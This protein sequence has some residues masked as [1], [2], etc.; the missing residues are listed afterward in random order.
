[1][2]KSLLLLSAAAL[3]AGCAT[4]VNTPD[5]A[6]EAIDT[7]TVRLVAEKQSPTKGYYE[8]DK[9]M[10]W[11]EGDEICVYVTNADYSSVE[12]RPI[13]LDQQYDGATKADFDITL[14]DGEYLNW[15][16]WYPYA[17]SP[18]WSQI[19]PYQITNG[20]PDKA[21]NNSINRMFYDQ[22]T[23]MVPMY[24][25]AKVDGPVSG[26]NEIGL[27]FKHIA[28]AFKFSF[29]G[30]PAD[31]N[32][33]RVTAYGKQ[34]SGGFTQTMNPLDESTWEL[35]TCDFGDENNVSEDN[36]MVVM[37][38]V[39]NGNPSSKDIYVPVPTGT[40]PKFKV[41][42]IKR[43]Y[44]YDEQTQTS[45][46][47]DVVYWE[48]TTTNPNTVERGQIV[49]MP[50]VDIPGL[51]LAGSFNNWDSDGVAFEDVSGHD[52]WKAV[53]N[54]ALTANDEFKITM[55]GGWGLSYGAK[56]A[57]KVTV[58][59]GDEYDVDATPGSQN[60][61]VSADG[62]YDIYFQPVVGTLVVLNA[63]DPF[64]PGEVH[65]GWNLYASFDGTGWD[66]IEMA[67]EQIIDPETQNPMSFRTV[68]NVEVVN[69]AAPFL[70]NLN[71]KWDYKFGMETSGNF[72]VDY[73]TEM[74]LGGADAYIETA[75]KYD[76]YFHA[77]ENNN[78]YEGYLL[79]MPAGQQPCWTYSVKGT[80]NNWGPDLEATIGTEYIYV[81]NVE[82]GDNVEFILRYV[83]GLQVVHATADEVLPVGSYAIGDFSGQ[84]QY[85]FKFA[86]V[87]GEKY[88]ILVNAQTGEVFVVKT[89]EWPTKATGWNLIGIGGHWD[90]YSDILM[91]DKTVDN[92]VWRF[93]GNVACVAD[94]EFQFRKDAD[95]QEQAGWQEL[96]SDQKGYPI[97]IGDYTVFDGDKNVRIADAG[98][99]DFYFDPQTRKGIVVTAG[100]D[101]PAIPVEYSIFVLDE[102]GWNSLG[103]IV[104]DA[105]DNTE[106]LNTDITE[107]ET[108]GNF[109]YSTI[110]F[111]TAA[112]GK[113]VNIA[114]TN[115]YNTL[116]DDDLKNVTLNG[117]IYTRTNG[118]MAAIISDPE[119][120]DDYNYTKGPWSITGEFNGWSDYN[121]TIH[122]DYD[123]SNGT[124]TAENVHFNAGE[125]FKFVMFDSWGIN[126]GGTVTTLGEPFDVTPN[127]DNIV[128]PKSGTYTVTL[129]DN[130]TKATLTL[131]AEDVE[132]EYSVVGWYGDGNGGDVNWDVANGV[133][134]TKVN[135]DGWY[136]A[137]GI[138]AASDKK[139][140]FKFVHNKSWDDY[141]LGAA[142]N[143]AKEVNVLFD[144][145]VKN[146]NYNVVLN[147]AGTYDVYFNATLKQA[148]I[149]D[150]G[151]TFAVP[152]T[153]ETVDPEASTWGIVGSI[154][155]WN[156]DN[157]VAMK[158]VNGW[159]VA[160]GVAIE[161]GAQIKF[162]QNR[163]WA[164]MY[165]SYLGGSVGKD[166]KI[167]L[168]YRATENDSDPAS[169]VVAD[170]GTYDVYLN[171]TEK[172]AY[173]VDAGTTFAYWNEQWEDPQIV[174]GS[175]NWCLAGTMNG[176]A[177]SDTTYKLTW[178][179][180]EYKIENVELAAGDE[181]K[182][183]RDNSWDVNRGGIL[184]TLGV[185][186]DVTQ[187]GSNITV[188]DAGKYNISLSS[189]ASTA[190]VE[191][192]N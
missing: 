21:I 169:I 70:I 91:T 191:V 188:T 33:L 53:M 47:T 111:P 44:T 15:M 50:A 64:T 10:V 99:Y 156:K 38:D 93:A 68:K 121:G 120:P 154:N 140:D 77:S 28:G 66:Y 174:T 192:V 118:V 170:A 161:A 128:A 82:L 30:F 80:F 95:W 37:W 158:V 146:A 126:R 173:L 139:I 78:S 26:G 32:V 155:S 40:Y 103:I 76:F 122:M 150:A 144:L 167:L 79:I 57:D 48:R 27:Q 13:A 182:F 184:T 180:S 137:A 29:N 17:N 2:K 83:N 24:M 105:D 160:Y 113:K 1:M 22:G 168:V 132:Y 100:A 5:V 149:L 186:F 84:S 133:K 102:T 43:N 51:K 31:A 59:L 130:A 67:D 109:T 107:T 178:T 72:P 134:M 97:T 114:F 75:G 148:F 41:E 86:T 153:V 177:A 39:V 145:G 52:G 110:K 16:A 36:M 11:Q 127:G 165:G 61:V 172:I 9:T 189:D 138:P 164:P 179:G 46:Y 104:T 54:Q 183:V 4:E 166:T 8:N 35:K 71:G 56:G 162:I 23:G 60:F 124:F 73:F 181:F 18:F 185:S 142:L 20:A 135:D 175:D 90:S 85:N 119:N 171:T 157:P 25:F 123:N 101:L 125:A 88:D 65:Q 55:Y 89:G 106:Y 152:T 42:I 34:L 116:E 112:N 131:T 58:T 159:E 62:N 12:G 190:L 81:S 45:N 129:S 49:R 92:I 96:Q 63:G 163:A 74:K 7:H 69:D 94:D 6:P 14:D 115:G 151:S 141:E 87:A 117:D 136:V 98:N 187:G 176:W 143:L 19:N 3:L 147:G 108:F